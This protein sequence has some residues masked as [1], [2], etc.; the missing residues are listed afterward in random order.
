MKHDFNVMRNHASLVISSQAPKKHHKKLTPE[1][2][3]PMP[4]DNTDKQELT[5]EE[6]KAILDRSNK[7]R[8]IDG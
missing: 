5:K 6:V 4:D 2:L 1:R 7:R 3:F 8:G